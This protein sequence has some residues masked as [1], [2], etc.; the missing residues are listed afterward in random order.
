MESLRFPYY[1]S[2]LPGIKQGISGFF[3]DG[4][5]IGII[6]NISEDKKEAALELLKFFISKEYQIKICNEGGL[7]AYKEL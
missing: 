6:K 2:I 7:S 5:N 4:N 3:I 1:K